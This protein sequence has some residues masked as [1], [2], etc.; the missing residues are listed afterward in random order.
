VPPS[1]VGPDQLMTPGNEHGVLVE[2]GPPPPPFVPL[3]RPAPWSGWPSSWSTPG[4]NGGGQSLTDL[5]WTCIDLNSSILA[6]MPSYLVGAADT[7]DAEWLRTPDP[8]LYESWEIFAKELFRDYQLGEVFLLATARY[9]TGWPARFHVVPP[10][11]VDVDFDDGRRVYSIGR[12]DVSADMLHIR[13]SGSVDDAH[14]HG[15]LEAGSARLVAADMLLQY[16][17]GIASAGGIPPGILMHADELSAEQS[18]NLKAQWV[19]ARLSQIGEPAVLSGG[20]SF[21]TPQVNPKDMAL[22]ELSQLNESRIAVMLG[23]P[24]FL[25]GLPSGGDP[26]TYSNVTSLF[27]YHW[28]AG[29]R[30][31]AASVMGALSGWLLPRGTTIEL[32][33]DTYVEPEPLERAK[34]YEIY[35]KIGALSVDE[36]RELERFRLATFSEGIPR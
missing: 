21:E 7:L 20:V 5:A 24:P 1:T 11:S 2:E 16:A 15:P 19:N 8:D 4:W 23:V 26:M 31:K 14:G 6:A 9:A 28:R 35:A 33:A 32:N 25:V 36:I 22:V 27:L 17:T 12:V 29:L 10:W 30:P 18:A 13:Y 34:T 3:A